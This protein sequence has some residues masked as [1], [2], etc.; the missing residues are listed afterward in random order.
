MEY[1][2]RIPLRSKCTRC[3]ILLLSHRTYSLFWRYVRHEEWLFGWNFC[4]CEASVWWMDFLK[5]STPKTFAKIL[6]PKSS[7]PD[8]TCHL[9]V[10]PPRVT[11][12]CHLRH[13]II[14]TTSPLS[15][16]PNPNNHTKISLR[17]WR[18]TH[19]WGSSRFISSQ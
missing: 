5:Y 18:P 15:R 3:H 9:H 17:P 12:T 2:P 13:N 11:S 7:P 6:T 14:S 1:F 16:Y 10:L 4:V 8:S 19:S